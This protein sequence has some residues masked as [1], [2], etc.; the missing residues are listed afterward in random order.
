VSQ[1]QKSLVTI[2]FTPPVLRWVLLLP[3]IVAL[4]GAWFAVRW[5]VGNTVAEYTST[6]DAD[7][8][9]MARLAARWAPASALAHWRLG[10]LQE[11]DF[12]AANLAAAVSEYRA[13]VEA[14]PND[15]R[16]WMELGRALEAAGD[17]QNGEK[18]LRRA[19]ELAPAY[20]HPHW[21]YG[22][23]LL[24]EGRVDEAFVEL[25]RAAN[26]DSNM[27]P[28]VFALA[29]QV[30][31]EDD[32][33]IATALPSAPLR[34][35]FA[36]SLAT[37]DKPEAALR[38]LQTV[39][40]ADRKSQPATLDAIIA[41]LMDRHYYH[42]A[43]SVLREQ[44]N[45]A[46]ML[47]MPEQFWNGGFETSITNNDVRPFHW[48]IDSRTQAEI[49]LDNSR[50]QGGQHSLRIVFKSPSKLE[51]IPVSQ[52]VIVEPD[53]QYKLQFYAR[54]DGLV[55]ASS[56]LLAV[57]DLSYNFMASS[58]PLHSGT[59]DWQP[60]TITFKTRPKQ[61]GILV[62]FYRVS[63]GNDPVCPIFGTVWYDDFTLQRISGAAAP[64]PAGSR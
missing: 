48:L 59:N 29:S 52:I 18:A 32:S 25:A 54:T 23:L 62:T 40:S 13:A 45:D 7:G 37:A 50:P 5:Y 10:S 26:V 53:T 55:T 27:Q 42:A 31:G 38:V 8:I 35:E 20:S 64:R 28:A 2:N 58:P 51:N 1:T 61:E 11:R 14:E 60:V 56:P 9:E 22:N 47:P 43:I 33:R 4:L 63:C 44:S 39:S 41:A 21:Q 19:V 3:A 34:L 15:F 57:K 49:T 24:R 17:S 36:L 16:Y 6:P 12:S 46:A 30:F